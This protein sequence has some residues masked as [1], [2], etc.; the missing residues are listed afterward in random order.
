MKKTYLNLDDLCKMLDL[1]KS[2]IYSYVGKNKIP[3]IKLDGK[4][5][6]SENDL[7]EWLNSKKKPVITKGQKQ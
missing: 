5:L 1:S 4:L 6:F 2:T 7:N 3:C